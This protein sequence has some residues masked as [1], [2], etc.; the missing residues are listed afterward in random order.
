[1]A[2]PVSVLQE[3][4]ICA[5]VVNAQAVIRQQPRE[6]CRCPFRLTEAKIKVHDMIY[7]DILR[8]VAIWTALAITICSAR[9]FAAES[10][11]TLT[12]LTEAE[13][14][15]FLAE[16]KPL[17]TRLDELRKAPNTSPDRWA[18]AE[19]FVRGVVWAL[20]F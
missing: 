17:Q 14:S 3:T 15:A 12:P 19:I 20:D 9:A 18:D 13:R 11:A 16:L 6:R 7:A 8:L 1:M 4:D 2:S 5:R 10:D